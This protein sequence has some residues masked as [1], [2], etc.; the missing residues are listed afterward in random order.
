L[1]KGIYYETH[2]EEKEIP[3]L[4]INKSPRQ[5]WIEV[6]NK[7]REVYQ[8]T[9]I[10]YALSNAKADI[11]IITDLGFVNEARNIRKRNG[12]L[13]KISRPGRELGTDGREVELDIWT[14]FDLHVINN[15]TLDDLYNKALENWSLI[16]EKENG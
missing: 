8:D 14:D 11:I 15:G 9:W 16:F 13:V 7:L 12:Y 10:D 6:G 5:I 4:G 2:R 3:L 1:K